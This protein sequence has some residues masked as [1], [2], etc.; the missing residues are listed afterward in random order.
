MIGD[1]CLIINGNELV[2]VQMKMAIK[3]KEIQL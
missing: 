3:R 1:Q 2:V